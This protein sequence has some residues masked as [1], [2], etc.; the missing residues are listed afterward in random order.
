MFPS[1]NAPKPATDRTQLRSH[2]VPAALSAG[3]GGLGVKHRNCF[4]LLQRL[5][6]SGAILLRLCAFMADKGEILL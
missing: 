5:G 3:T 1:I 4:Y 6:I 2:R